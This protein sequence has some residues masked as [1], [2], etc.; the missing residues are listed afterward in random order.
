MTATSIDCPWGTDAGALTPVT[1]TSATAGGFTMIPMPTVLLPPLAS[2]SVWCANRVC[3]VTAAVAVFQAKSSVVL[4]PRGSPPTVW[5]PIV[6]PSVASVRTTS[7]LAP[8]S[9]S[10]VFWTVSPMCA[11]SP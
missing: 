7:K 10:P 9:R 2:A 6:V 1:A 11:V 5:L 3:P 8:T 4:A